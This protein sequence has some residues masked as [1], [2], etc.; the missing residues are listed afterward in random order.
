MPDIIDHIAQ[1]GDLAHLALVF[2]SAGWGAFVMSFRE[3]A[4]ANRRF[5]AFV[6]ELA[7]FNSRFLGD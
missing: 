5:E 2:A 6:R 3:L 1:R 7:R 4:R